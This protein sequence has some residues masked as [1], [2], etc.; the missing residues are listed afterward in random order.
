MKCVLGLILTNTLAVNV[1]AASF[2][3]TLLRDTI[4]LADNEVSNDSFKSIVA[5]VVDP[6][7]IDLVAP[8]P[9]VPVIDI[10]TI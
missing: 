3:L 4:A 6:I 8:T 9:V 10:S 7:T 2:A 1:L 5:D